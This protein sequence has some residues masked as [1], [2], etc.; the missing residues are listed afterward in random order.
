[1]RTAA[2]VSAWQ[3][4]AKTIR[5]CWRTRNWFCLQW[6]ILGGRI[7]SSHVERSRLKWAS[8]LQKSILG[9]RF[10]VLFNFRFIV[11]NERL[12][13]GIAC[14]E[15][16]CSVLRL[17]QLLSLTNFITLALTFRSWAPAFLLLHC[18]SKSS[19]DATKWKCFDF[20]K[21]EHLWWSRF[22]AGF[23]S[24]F[25]LLFSPHS[26]WFQV[27]DARFTMKTNLSSWCWL[28]WGDGGNLQSSN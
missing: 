19:G 12:P 16:I 2:T 28:A 15:Q 6:S 7:K 18:S 17:W 20:S 14:W 24:R 23:W 26:Q 21:I 25:G 5:H 11:S 9:H 10:S 27:K 1:M 22:T 3:N 8:A 13:C 4:H